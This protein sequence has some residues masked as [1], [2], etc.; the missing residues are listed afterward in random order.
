M[1]FEMNKII[2]AILV[3]M[4]VAM[5]SGILAEHLVRPVMLAQPVYAIAAA[6]GA[7][8]APAEAATAAAAGPEPVEPLLAQA[9]VDAGKADTKLC[10]AC[11]TFEKGQPNRVG[12]NLYGIVGDKIAEA[13]D[14][15]G[16][17]FSAA[18]KAKGGTW[19]VDNLNEWLFKPQ[20]FAKGTKMTY[21]GM[22]KAKERA[23]LI[24]YLNSLSDSPKP[25][26][27]K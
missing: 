16:Y 12:P 10:T 3:A 13:A 1:T 5:V 23:D 4:I 18:L 20:N 14:R 19:T 11:H 26:A 17:D 15:G 7:T 8:G 22:P 25:L 27:G 2:G 6:P 24:A 9:S 21:A